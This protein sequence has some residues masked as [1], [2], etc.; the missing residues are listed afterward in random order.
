MKKNILILLT[1]IMIVGCKKE[2]TP[3]PKSVTPP[4][5]TPAVTTI[6]AMYQGGITCYIDA[7][8]N[9]GLIASP[10]DQDTAIQWY[11]ATN[12]QL[13]T[14][15]LY[16]ENIGMGQSNTTTITSWYGPGDYAAYICDTLTLNGYTDWFLPSRNELAAMIGSLSPGNGI[17]TTAFYLSST[18]SGSNATWEVQGGSG[19]IR[20]D[21]PNI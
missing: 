15:T 6:G 7:S 14:G 9:H 12:S 19:S 21:L 5:T 13:F 1:A 10:F 3:A 16:Y 11:Y 18:E 17:D 4:P 20:E 8:G 2:E